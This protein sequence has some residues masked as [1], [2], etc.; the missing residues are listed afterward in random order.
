MIKSAC[1]RYKK[2][3]TTEPYQYMEGYSHTI[4]YDTLV[5]MDIY[6]RVS[7]EKY[8][9]TEGF[10]CVDNRFV[11]R[12]EAM[13]IARKYNLLKDCYKHTD[14]PILYSYMVNYVRD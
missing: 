6:A 2:L 9:V 11:D 13:K 3:G 12:I 5:L 10:M 7:P 14:S 1:V 4:C 8:D